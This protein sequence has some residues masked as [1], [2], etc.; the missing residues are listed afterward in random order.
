MPAKTKWWLCG[1]CSFANRPRGVMANSLNTL[2]PG[3]IHDNQVCEQCGASSADPDAVD[4]QPTG[5]F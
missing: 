3:A 4:Y 5:R 1:R 2:P